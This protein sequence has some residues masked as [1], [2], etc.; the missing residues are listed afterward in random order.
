[1]TQMLAL[2]L[3]RAATLAAA[4]LDDAVAGFSTTSNPNGNWSYGT[5][6]PAFYEFAIK[7]P[8]DTSFDYWMGNGGLPR[9]SLNTTAV[10]IQVDNILHPI[11]YVN[12]TPN[13]DYLAVLRW[14]APADGD[15]TFSG[16]FR[17][18]DNLSHGM[19]ASIVQNDSTMLFDHVLSSYL[20]QQTFQFSRTLAVGAFIDFIAGSYNG[21]PMVE[22][23]YVWES[24]GVRVEVS[25]LSEVPEPGTW[26][27]VLVGSALIFV[28]RRG[29]AIMGR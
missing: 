12:L 13:S 8:A 1:M 19:A 17:L 28:S 29:A 25:S 26:A 20:E 4:P 24:L 2:L 16:A 10:A 5:R 18:H 22:D 7:D 6:L 9:V 15:Y 27:L 11:D 21:Q 14:T 3:L 23:F